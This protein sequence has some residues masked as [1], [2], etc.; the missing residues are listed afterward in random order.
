MDDI[1]EE[2]GREDGLDD[3]VGEEGTGCGVELRETVERVG[4][5]MEVGCAGVDEM[6]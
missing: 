2:F 1:D 5:M 3:D 4:E 6:L